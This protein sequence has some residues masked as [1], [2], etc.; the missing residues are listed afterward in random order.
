MRVFLVCM[1]ALG[2]AS[3]RLDQQAAASALAALPDTHGFVRLRLD[4]DPS[5]THADGDGR[6]DCLPSPRRQRGGPTPNY[7]NRWV[8]A[9]GSAYRFTRGYVGVDAA[10]RVYYVSRYAPASRRAP[11]ASHSWVSVFRQA[12]RYPEAVCGYGC[13][14]YYLLA[15]WNR[16][17]GM[18]LDV[19][20]TLAFRNRSMVARWYSARTSSPLNATRCAFWSSTPRTDDMGWASRAHLQGYDSLQILDGQFGYPELII[21]RA[22]CL[23][24]PR[25]L[26][27]CPPEGIVRA[28]PLETPP[29]E[30]TYEQ[31]RDCVCADGAYSPL[32]TNDRI[33]LSNCA[34]TGVVHC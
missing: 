20:R 5:T 3:R 2:R 28:V 27:A 1:L 26:A 31:T 24:Q 33:F 25:P 9:N 22:A 13:W 32:K 34:G 15:P 14:F 18:V 17:T 21:T 29:E 8:H 19:G 7:G 12:I 6:Q 11:A 30:I 16:G 10:A 23:A 4:A